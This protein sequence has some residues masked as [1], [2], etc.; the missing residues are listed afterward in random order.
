MQAFEHVKERTE[1]TTPLFTRTYAVFSREKKRRERGK[2]GG[3]V[4][5][6]NFRD[7]FYGKREGR[8]KALI[9]FNNISLSFFSILEGK[10]KGRGRENIFF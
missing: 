2:A 3:S 5:K 10:R 6:R 1:Q 4:P 9:V 7:P 8:N